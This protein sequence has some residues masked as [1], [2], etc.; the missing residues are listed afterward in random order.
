MTMSTKENKAVV[1]RFFEECWNH[2]DLAVLEEC[3]A[4][5]VRLHSAR[6]TSIQS[7]EWFREGVIRWRRAFP[8]YQYVLDHVIAEGDTVAVNTRF[9]GTHRD[10]FQW[11]SYGPW[12]PTGKTIEVM[13]M[14]VFRF[15][16]GRVVDLWAVWDQITFARQ[17]GVSLAPA[18]TTT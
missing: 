16:E 12:A 9:T 7:Q 15:A 13:E 5:N 2:G 4:P 3:L 6:G 17:L 18:G 14:F 11:L 1:R 10:V 8:D